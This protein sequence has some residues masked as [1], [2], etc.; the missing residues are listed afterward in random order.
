MLSVDLDCKLQLLSQAMVKALQSQTRQ[1]NSILVLLD[2]IFCCIFPMVH[3]SILLSG[4]CF[5]PFPGSEPLPP[6]HSSGA[7]GPR[8]VYGRLS[9]WRG[10]S[11]RC[12]GPVRG[13]GVLVAFSVGHG[14]MAPTNIYKPWFRLTSFDPGMRGLFMF[15]KNQQ[16]PLC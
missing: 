4:T 5:F 1:K 12:G 10:K 2:M 6:R 15:A 14:V 11:G 9:R 13:A 8:R 3:G 7:R 16:G